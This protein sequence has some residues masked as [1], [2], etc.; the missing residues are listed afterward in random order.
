MTY[1]G[2]KTASLKMT[3]G[4]FQHS[5]IG[6]HSQWGKASRAVN[7]VKLYRKSFFDGEISCYRFSTG[8]FINSTSLGA[9]KENASPFLPQAKIG[10]KGFK[11]MK[12][13]RCQYGCGSSFQPFL[14]H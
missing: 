11:Y 1:G 6:P 2:K 9:N 12:I 8:I 3:S 5:W 13:I 14:A 7:E 10:V 4:K